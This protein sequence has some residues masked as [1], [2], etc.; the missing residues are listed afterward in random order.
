[1][2]PKT[3]LKILVT[4][5]FF[6]L[7]FFL[8]TF[9]FHTKKTLSL[10]D[11]NCYSYEI[12]SS[13]NSDDF[14]RKWYYEEPLEIDNHKKQAIGINNTIKIKKFIED[15]IEKINNENKNINIHFDYNDITSNDLYVLKK[16]KKSIY[17]QYY[18]IEKNVLYEIYY[19][20]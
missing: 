1:M 10:Y 5:M 13:Q 20:Q 19:E 7:I 3:I 17:L 2:K 9:L 8:G 6:V 4:I 16:N 11:D 14:L 18:D 15:G 12:Y